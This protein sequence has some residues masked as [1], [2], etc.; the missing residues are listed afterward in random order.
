MA[1]RE[2]ARPGLQRCIHASNLANAPRV[3]ARACSFRHAHSLLRSRAMK[4]LL[5]FF[6]GIGVVSA[7]A[8][9]S[10]AHAAEMKAEVVTLAVS[11]MT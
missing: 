1:I 9:K 4:H 5:A 8:C 11:G 6:L 2:H 7:A 3:T 10:D